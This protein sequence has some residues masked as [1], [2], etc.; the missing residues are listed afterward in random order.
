MLGGSTLKVHNPSFSLGKLL[1]LLGQNFAVT[2]KK[3][4][5]YIGLAVE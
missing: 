5:C 3:V 2:E 4:F 1:P